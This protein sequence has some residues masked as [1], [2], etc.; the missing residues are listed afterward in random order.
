VLI[1]IAKYRERWSD[2]RLIML[3]LNNQDLDQ[4]TWEQRM[5]A[6][7]PKLDVSQSIPTFPMRAS[8]SCSGQGH[9]RELA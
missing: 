3:V 6:G 2:P 9:T 7:N 8:R 5:L 4:V 1:D